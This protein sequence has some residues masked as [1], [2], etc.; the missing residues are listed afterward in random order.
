MSVA[1]LFIIYLFML[2]WTVSSA[3][4]SRDTRRTDVEVGAFSLSPPF[5]K[6][7]VEH[8]KPK[9]GSQRRTPSI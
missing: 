6:Y 1:F 7:S 5:K 8:R 4:P 3:Q 2:Q 9:Q